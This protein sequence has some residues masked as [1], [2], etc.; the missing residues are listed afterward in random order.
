LEDDR[1]KDIDNARM[2]DGPEVEIEPEQLEDHFSD[3]D[4]SNGEGMN[5]LLMQNINLH[6]KFVVLIY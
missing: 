5:L 6:Y 4:D 2:L 1:I 3:D